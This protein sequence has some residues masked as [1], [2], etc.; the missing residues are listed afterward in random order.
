MEFIIDNKVVQIE[1]N[2][3][4]KQCNHVFISQLINETRE[5]YC[6]LCGMSAHADGN[7]NI[8]C[9]HPYCKCMR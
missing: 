3:Q 1:Q 5:R 9:G 6:K 2:E 8:P 4:S 7:F